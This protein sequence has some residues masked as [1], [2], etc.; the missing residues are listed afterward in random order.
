[1][2][3]VQE[4]AKEPKS[5]EEIE[6]ILTTALQEK[7]PDVERACL[8]P[9]DGGWQCYV[10]RSMPSDEDEPITE[11]DHLLAELLERYVIVD[12]EGVEDA[13]KL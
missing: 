10:V 11:G 4:M 7:Y 6:D 1:L 9:G 2:G 13:G 12:E 3:K 8:E 5:Q